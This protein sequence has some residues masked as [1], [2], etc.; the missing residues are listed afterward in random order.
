VILILPGSYDDETNECR[1]FGR[2]CR[3][4]Y[5]CGG[6]QPSSGSHPSVARGHGKGRFSTG[7]ESLLVP[8][9]M[10]TWLGLAR[11]LGL[12]QTLGLGLRTTRLGLALR[13]LGLLGNRCRGWRSCRRFVL[14]SCP[15]PLRLA[16]GARVLT[17]RK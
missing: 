17:D 7:R 1:A 14:A 8:M 2:Y 15:W 16:L 11:G 9:G 12:A 4:R 5:N 13:T 10:R 6:N 3:R